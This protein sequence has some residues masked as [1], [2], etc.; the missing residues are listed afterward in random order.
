MTARL[1]RGRRAQHVPRP[2]PP[3]AASLTPDRKARRR[4]SRSARPAAGTRRSAAARRGLPVE[5]CARL[6]NRGAVFVSGGMPES[7]CVRP[8]GRPPPGSRRRVV[9]GRRPGL[10]PP[11]VLQREK[12]RMRVDLDEGRAVEGR[13]HLRDLE[14]AP[15]HRRDLRDAERAHHDLGAE[16]RHL[17]SRR[18][19]CACSTLCGTGGSESVAGEDVRSGSPAAR[20]DPTAAGSAGEISC[21]SSRRD[22][23]PGAARG[24]D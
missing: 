24:T 13:R 18:S 5:P 9:A 23:L 14:E 22:R 16:V 15:A 6:L 10:S 4:S 3:N 7:H 1:Q 19:P 12:P 20:R 8:G 11:G 17:A 21:S 2:P